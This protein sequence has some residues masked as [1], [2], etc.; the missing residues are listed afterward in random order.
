MAPTEVRLTQMTDEQFDEW[1]SEHE[2]SY[3]ETL[4]SRYGLTAE[5]AQRLAQNEVR[6]ALP[7]GRVTPGMHV[8]NVTHGDDVVGTL[9]WGAHSSRPRT[10]YV[11]DIVIRPTHRGRGFGRA[12]M[13]AAENEARTSGAD[14]LGLSVTVSNDAARRLY[15]SLG[16]VAASLSMTKS[17][18]RQHGR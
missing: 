15:D 6:T 14:S 12:T 9:W 4:S 10:A 2:R 1:R 16:F 11:Y 3:A 18:G 8:L 13:I 17:I 7:G 5:E